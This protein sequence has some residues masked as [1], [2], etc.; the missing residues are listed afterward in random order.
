MNNFLLSFLGCVLFIFCIL[1]LWHLKQMLK[2][3]RLLRKYFRE[4]HIGGYIRK[5]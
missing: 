5:D 1:D 3:L 2:E 4:N